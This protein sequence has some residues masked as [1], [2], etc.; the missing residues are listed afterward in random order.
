MYYVYEYECSSLILFD[1]FFYQFYFFIVFGSNSSKPNNFIYYIF[2]INFIYNFFFTVFDDS[3][4]FP[5]CG[6][7]IFFVEIINFFGLENDRLR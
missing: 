2:L 1:F 7:K 6:K 5:F 4:K 3:H